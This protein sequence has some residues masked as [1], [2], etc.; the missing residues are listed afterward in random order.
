MMKCAYGHFNILE[1]PI[2]GLSLILRQMESLGIPVANVLVCC[3]SVWMSLPGCP[4]P[5]SE[6]MGFRW[7]LQVVFK[8]LNGF[9]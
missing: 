1:S 7:R 5:R 2:I 8:V 4:D 9:G 6:L 3:Q